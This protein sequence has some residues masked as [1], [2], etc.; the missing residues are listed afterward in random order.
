MIKELIDNEIKSFIELNNLKLKDFSTEFE[1]FSAK[2]VLKG[3]NFTINDLANGIVDGGGDEGIDSI[4]CIIDED[5]LDQ[6][7][8][9]FDD[10]YSLLN[11]SSIVRVIIIQSKAETGFKEK[12]VNGIKRGIECIF[13]K[14]FDL[15]NEKFKKQAKMI[16]NLYFAHNKKGCK[17]KIT[18]E[19][20]YCT[21]A[22]NKDNALNN[23]RVVREKNNVCK[24]VENQY[25][26]PKF[27]FLG[28][29]ELLDICKKP[30]KYR[31]TLKN[32]KKFDYPK[33]KD[34][35]VEGC[36]CLVNVK[37]YLEFITD[38]NK[39][40]EDKIFE[41]NIRD[42]QGNSKDVNKA[43]IQTIRTDCEK[44]WCMNNGI[45]IIA[46]DVDPL[47]NEVSM[48]NYQIVNGCQTSYAIYET[49]KE[50]D[51]EELD[52]LDFELVVKIIEIKKD[53]E[54]NWDE[55]LVLNIIKSTNSQIEIKDFAFE[56]NRPIH[57]RIEQYFKMLEKPLYYERK[58][59]FYERRGYAKSRILNPKELF[60]AYYSIYY[61]EA[62]VVRNNVSMYFE[63]NK[64]KVFNTNINLEYYGISYIIYNTVSNK[65]IELKG[66]ENYESDKIINFIINNG[67]LHISRVVFSLLNG[68][69][70]KLTNLKRSDVT[71]CVNPNVY[72]EIF[73]D[74]LQ[75][76]DVMDVAIQIIKSAILEVNKDKQDSLERIMKVSLLD[77]TITK[78]LVKYH[79]EKTDTQ[80][81]LEL[82]TK[83]ILSRLQRHVRNY[84]EIFKNISKNGDKRY[85]FKNRLNDY[86][87]FLN[88]YSKQ[89]ALN[90]NDLITLLK[91]IRAIVNE[92][93]R[94]SRIDCAKEIL[95]TNDT[96]RKRLLKANV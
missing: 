3:N 43:I 4:Y 24:Y 87:Y 58:P 28:C 77:D 16:R 81:S 61:K 64:D 72:N 79:E 62:S 90:L 48:S 65:L 46:Y 96:I 44:F 40:I 15:S 36:I 19:M 1:Y 29:N 55:D 32:L 91:D 26:K 6:S 47:E 66:N 41:E 30:V 60:K 56:S 76:E 39:V 59:Q 7:N 85:Y 37:E 49:L 54:G 45:T 23:D 35:I 11:K 93:N 13:D 53:E 57:K 52:K 83:Y 70:L 88:M 94:E 73:S 82:P 89:L 10:I 68:G 95:N 69:D 14:D 86:I 50:I 38:D 34:N 9:S 8:S 42:Y 20:Y 22:N 63:K 67:L 74:N 84:D 71:K 31:K 2:N 51:E 17:E 33:R 92:N 75:I 12:V 25:M 78:K 18:L 5:I 80:I 21:K 27:E